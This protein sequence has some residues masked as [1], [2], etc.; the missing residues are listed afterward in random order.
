MMQENLDLEK[1]KSRPKFA[2]KYDWEF[3]KWVKKKQT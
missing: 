1:L 3:I 2:L